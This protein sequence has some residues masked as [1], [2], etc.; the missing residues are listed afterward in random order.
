M[1]ERFVTSQQTAVTPMPGAEPIETLAD[2]G[3]GRRVGVLLAHGFTSTPQ[4]MRGWAAELQR[5][6]WSVSVPLL[7]GHGTTW[8]D[9]NTTGWHDWYGELEGALARLSEHCE[10]VVIAGLSMGGTLA[11]RLTQQYGPTSLGDRLL[12][13]MLIN[14]SLSTERRDAFLLP[15]LQRFVG[16]FPGISNDVAK[17]GVRELAYTRL[18]L[19]AAYSLQ[20]LWGI[21]RGDLGMVSTPVVLYQSATDH[22]VEPASARI[23]LSGIAS[24]DVSH[25]VLP[26]SFHVATLD[27]DA[28]YIFDT[29]RQWISDRLGTT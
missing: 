10:K 15:L 26:R 8:R 2:T 5:S 1:A 25:H 27:Y 29:S 7:P 24:T 18:P 28:Q 23:L 21:T 17:P 20:E 22:I 9:M 6:G 13:T 16:S 12:G 19:R 11:I 14:P 4:A 3:E